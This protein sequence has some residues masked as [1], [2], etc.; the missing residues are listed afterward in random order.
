METPPSIGTH[1]QPPLVVVKEERGGEEDRDG[2]HSIRI[3]PARECQ[4]GRGQCFQ[5][6][7]KCPETGACVL[8]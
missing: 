3:A 8:R 4:A 1:T 6:L 2:V 7:E 5:S